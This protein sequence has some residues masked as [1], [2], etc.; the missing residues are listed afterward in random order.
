MILYTFFP[1][2]KINVSLITTNNSSFYC[3]IK[4][5]EGKYEEILV[6]NLSLDQKEDI[7]KI[8]ESKY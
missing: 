4:E 3:L 5:N 8:L 1:E 6:G 2:N 7:I